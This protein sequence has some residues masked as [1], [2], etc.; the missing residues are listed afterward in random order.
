LD[1]APLPVV[2]EAVTKVFR[3]GPRGFVTPVGAFD[4]ECRPGPA[5]PRLIAR[6]TRDF[7]RT[8]R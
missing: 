8:R 3:V 1:T 2:D 7:P 4:R 5:H 6:G